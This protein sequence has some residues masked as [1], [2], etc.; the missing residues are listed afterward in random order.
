MS[1]K[2]RL[3]RYPTVSKFL[4]ESTSTAR[5]T[6][7]NNVSPA[8]GRMWQD[9]QDQNTFLLESDTSTIV[10]GGKRALKRIRSAKDLASKTVVE[11]SDSFKTNIVPASG[12]M[13][14][15]LQDENTL[16]LESD[17]SE[18]V[19]DGKRALRHMKTIK[20]LASKA[21]VE[22]TDSMN[23]N[24]VPAS[25]RMWEGFQNQNT[26]LLESDISEIVNDGRKYLKRMRNFKD[27]A[28]KAVVETT[29]DSI[30]NQVVPAS[31]RM[32][33]GFHNQNKIFLDYD[34]STMIDDDKRALKRMRTVKHLAS[35][36]ISKLKGNFFSN[37]RVQ[38]KMNHG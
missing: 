12:R 28:S 13:W 10:D 18:I 11:T 33:E 36:A 19:D 8:C 31:G 1:N 9:Y 4:E 3:L 30:N 27:L 25:G 17:T 23:K 37:G 6:L 14:E 24:F 20:D 29:T 32:W 38:N 21:V 5:R 2:G 35:K 34:A 22:T 7:I 16:L 26:F 15:G